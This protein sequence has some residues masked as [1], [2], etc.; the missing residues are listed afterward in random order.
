MQRVRHL[1]PQYLR[2]R[3]ALWIY[4][5]R[6]PEA[7]WLTAESIRLLNCLLRPA[8]RGLEFGAG[9]S[10]LWLG[11]R[12]AGL[13]S[14]ETAP[15]WHRFVSTTLTRRRMMHVECV[16]IPADESLIDDPYRSEYL[17]SADRFA[18]GSLDY[19][20]VDA[21]YRGE[22]ALRSAELLKPGGLL[23]IDNAE[24]YLPSR[25]RSPERLRHEA[26]PVWQLFLKYVAGWRC[27]W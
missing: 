18:S 6:H 15:A 12:T 26:T 8:D 19:V 20:L 7:P 9:R 22:C 13:L 10:T 16:L 1:T 25:T 2:D 4:Y 5:R 11:E 17:A 24:R 23:V 21:I 27:A 14:V 3:V